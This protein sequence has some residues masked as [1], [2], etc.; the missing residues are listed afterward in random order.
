MRL[1]AQPGPR[2]SLFAPLCRPHG[3]APPQPANRA[4]SSPPPLSPPGPLQAR[5]CS[6]RG[7]TWAWQSAR[8]TSERWGPTRWSSHPATQPQR[9]RAGVGGCTSPV[10]QPAELSVPGARPARGCALRSRCSRLTALPCWLLACCTPH[11]CLRRALR[12]LPWAGIGLLSRAAVHLMAADP[13]LACDSSTSVAAA[14]EFRGMVSQLHAAGIEVYLM[15][16]AGP[17]WGPGGR[18]G[19]SGLQPGMV[20]AP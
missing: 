15:V 4:A 16:G 2:C 6:T 10:S 5:R 3:S 19:L 14:A 13:T 12:P 11:S 1:R 17:V 18:G 20:H 8:R 9:V 7:R